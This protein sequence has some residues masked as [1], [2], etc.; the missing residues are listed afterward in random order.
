MVASCPFCTGELPGS[1][2]SGRS[3]LKTSQAHVTPNK[4]PVPDDPVLLAQACLSY[5]KHAPKT[6][7]N[8]QGGLKLNEKLN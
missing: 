3:V 6:V 8:I 2:V 1:E 5:I 4:R 7:K